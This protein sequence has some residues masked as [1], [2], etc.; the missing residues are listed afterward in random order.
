MGSSSPDVPHKGADPVDDRPEQ[1]GG[2]TRE[3]LK[4]WARFIQQTGIR[5]E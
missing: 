4:P 3:E 1:F 5:P 2:Q